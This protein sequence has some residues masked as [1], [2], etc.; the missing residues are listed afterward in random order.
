MQKERQ[1]YEDRFK[2]LVNDRDMLIQPFIRSITTKGEASLMLFNGEYTHAIL[3][4][5]KPGDY[6]VQDD[7]GGTVSPYQ[8]T[9]KEIAFAEQVFASCDTMPA[10]GRADIVWDEA[11]NML[12]GELEIIE[13]ELWVRNHP[14][15]AE[16]FAN[17]ILTYLNL[18][19]K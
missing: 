1:T 5:A 16:S 8:P 2:K 18:N 10:Y 11:G 19:N 7:F 4:K 14:E 6:R 9:Q 3:K 13:P 15:N 12:L 17:G